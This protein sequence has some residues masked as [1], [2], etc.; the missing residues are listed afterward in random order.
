MNRPATQSGRGFAAQRTGRLIVIAGPSGAG[1]GTLI[2]RL[3]QLVPGL[4]LSVS[5]TTR[6]KRRG[7]KDGREYFFL[8]RD[9]FALWIEE[10]R[11][12]EW[13]EYAGN[14]YGT[15]AEAVHDN[16]A[17]GLDVILEIELQGAGEVLAHCPE[18]VMIYIV[19]PSLEELERRLRG[20]K[21]ESEEAIVRRLARAKEELAEVEKKMLHDHSRLHHVIVNDDVNR[22]GERLA[23]II[24][25]IREEDEQAH[26]R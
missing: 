15:P 20:R 7:E 11:F 2:G 22:A 16:L 3:L 13:A 14:R 18:A 25:R 19:P 5:A 23:R 4:V 17:A 8:S 24:E 10:G 12:L 6:D 1:K 21:T 9:Q 26:S